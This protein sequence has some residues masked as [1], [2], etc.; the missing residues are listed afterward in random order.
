M[1]G[2][3]ELENKIQEIKTLLLQIRA[4]KGSKGSTFRIDIP[5]DNLKVNILFGKKNYIT[6][7]IV[8]ILIKKIKEGQPSLCLYIEEFKSDIFGH[9][10]EEK[11]IQLDTAINVLN[12]ISKIANY[13]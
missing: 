3:K 12:E 9:Y 4:Q 11:A 6:F 2:K 1:S 8:T 7:N 5:K 13:E 10:M